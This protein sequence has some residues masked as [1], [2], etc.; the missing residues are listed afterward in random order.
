MPGQEYDV[1]VVLDACAYSWS[2]GQVLR[3]S[4]PGPTGRTR[5][6]RRRRSTLTVHAA[7]VALPVLDGT[8]RRRP[9]GRAPST[10]SESAEGIG[11]SI[12]DDVLARR[13][14]ARTVS[15]SEYAT[16]YDGRAREDYRGEVWVDRRTFAQRAHAVTTYDLA[17]PDV[18]WCI[19]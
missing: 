9:S 2:P 5:S 6:R 3:V 11:W 19:E 1:E 10:S 16:P 14:T 17:W 7:E 18:E 15:V 8:T 4:S 13:T 12:E